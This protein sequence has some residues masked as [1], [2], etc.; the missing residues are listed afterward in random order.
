MRRRTLT[1][2]ALLTIWAIASQTSFGQVVHTE[3]IGPITVVPGQAINLFF[4]NEFDL[5]H[6]KLVRFEGKADIVDPL[7]LTSELDIQFDWLDPATG[8]FV[9]SP[10][11]PVT[12]LPGAV[13]PID[14]RFEI[15]FCPQEVSLHL[16]SSAPV[17]VGGV[18]THICQVPEPS[19]L[20]LAGF[21]AGLLGCVASRRR[22]G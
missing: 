15:P 4:P 8:G 22:R 17:R 16:T 1:T 20:L 6:T 13:K 12:V 14:V 18:F 2:L 10:V 11:F 5:I 21:G 9:L 19:S 3:P 7:G